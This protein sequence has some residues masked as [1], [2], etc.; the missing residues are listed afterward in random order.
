M[1]GTIFYKRNIR[2]LYPPV[3]LCPFD[4]WSFIIESS[5]HAMWNKLIFSKRSLTVVNISKIFFHC[6]KMSHNDSE[7]NSHIKIINM[8]HDL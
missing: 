4:P 2:I 5:H 3:T 6:Y 7:D 8:K 1:L